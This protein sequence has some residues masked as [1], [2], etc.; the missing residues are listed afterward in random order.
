MGFGLSIGWFS[1]LQVIEIISSSFSQQVIHCHDVLSNPS[2]IL[3]TCNHCSSE[4]IGH[5]SCLG[6]GGL[7]CK[8]GSSASSVIISVLCMLMEIAH[9]H[10]PC[11]IC[12]SSNFIPLLT[13]EKATLLSRR[14]G[15]ISEKSQKQKVSLAWW[16]KMSLLSSP[17]FCVTFNCCCEWEGL[18]SAAR[19]P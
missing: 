5:I 9:Y 1:E 2:V 12:S 16:G 19:S 15:Y 13:S 6:S 8:L 7:P 17:F 14:M 18:H 3:L 11:N 10:E 4:L